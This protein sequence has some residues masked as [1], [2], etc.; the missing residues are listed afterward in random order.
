MTSRAADT[1][2]LDGFEDLLLHE[3]LFRH[4]LLLL[5][6]GSA[7]QDSEQESQQERSQQDN[8]CFVL[9]SHI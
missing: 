7:H 8:Q 3:R 6:A 1:P 2:V 5:A 4:G 9:L